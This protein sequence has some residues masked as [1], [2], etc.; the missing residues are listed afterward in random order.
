M[1]R[2]PT[3]IAPGQRVSAWLKISRNDFTGS[4]SFDVENLPHGI[5]VADIGLNGVLI[6]E[7]ETERQVFLQCP[8]W[9]EETDRLCYAKAREADG[10]TGKPV[11]IHVRRASR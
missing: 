3:Q 11:M 8:S 4:V 2:A 5:I 7:G 6:P 1:C 10:P 9:V